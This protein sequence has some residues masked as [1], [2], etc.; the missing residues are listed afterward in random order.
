ML[1]FLAPR[2]VT[3][4][5]EAWQRGRRW[6]NARRLH[7]LRHG[8]CAAC[9]SSTRLHVHHVLPPAVA[10]AE[11]YEGGNLV[12]L[13]TSYRYGV[14]C[15]LFFGHCGNWGNYNPHVRTHAAEF[16]ASLTMHVA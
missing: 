7:L 6:R 15:H 9:G 8:T 5:A 11:L 1:R 10:P 2:Q 13:C 14:N 12:T 3:P 16:L 4:P